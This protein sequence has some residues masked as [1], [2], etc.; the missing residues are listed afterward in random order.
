MTRESCGAERT[1]MIRLQSES[2]PKGVCYL[3]TYYLLR[4]IRLQSESS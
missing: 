4:M 3:L 1:G 2:L